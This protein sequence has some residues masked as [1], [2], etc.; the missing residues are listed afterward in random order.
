MQTQS[1][2]QNAGWLSM[3]RL[4]DRVAVVTGAASG[5]GRALCLQLAN[6]GC[7]IAMADVDEEGLQE[8]RR[9]LETNGM[10]CTT[11]IV[12]VA[13]RH[14]VERF[15][16]GVEDAHGGAHL[17][18]NNA[19]VTLVEA[20]ENIEYDDFEW[21]MNVNFWGVVY[22][23][24]AFLPL[25]RQQDEAHIVNISSL[26]G[27]MALP[28][29]SAY[30]ASKFAV[31]GFSEA[32]KM[33]LSTSPVQV[34]CVHPGGV[35]TQIAANARFGRT[36]P[37]GSRRK[38]TRTFDQK[39]RTTPQGAARTIIRGILRN[40]RRIIVGAD[41]SIADRVVRLFPGTYERLLGLEK[42]MQKR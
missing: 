5:I 11:H 15:A 19:G 23:S 6:E 29:Q 32:L 42:L 8:S 27:L 14:A 12:D 2:V 37:A 34:S 24:K 30:N 18:I 38:L 21:L 22:G 41:A 1:G 3:K 4:Q 40:K 31:R 28:L 13:D 17:L 9:L 16:C 39:A 35:K 20:A 26:F 36:A 10:L 25:L 33:E 7:Q